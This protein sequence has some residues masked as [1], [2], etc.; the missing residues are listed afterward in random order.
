MEGQ[1]YVYNKSAWL[2]FLCSYIF[3]NLMVYVYY[4]VNVNFI[5]RTG[6]FIPQ[7]IVSI[8]Y[9][10]LPVIY[11]KL[12]M[13]SFFGSALHSNR[14]CILPV[15]CCSNVYD[16]RNYSVIS[17]NFIVTIIILCLFLLYNISEESIGISLTSIRTAYY[18]DGQKNF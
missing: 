10:L 4:V 8:V 14:G 3:D 17:T 1:T 7:L 11:V 5:V 9:T 16:R 12:L 2:Y 15:Y 13:V 6:G 18:H